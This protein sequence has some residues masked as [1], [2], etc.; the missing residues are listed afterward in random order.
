MKLSIINE[1]TLTA[2]CYLMKHLYRLPAPRGS[3]YPSF[4]ARNY[5]FLKEE[6][7]DQTVS[8]LLLK[9]NEEVGFS[10]KKRLTRC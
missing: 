1:K 5:P 2:R 3:V 8:L 7:F 6:L 4:Q 9:K 10:F